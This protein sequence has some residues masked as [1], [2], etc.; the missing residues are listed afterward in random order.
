MDEIFITIFIFILIGAFFILLGIPLL[1]EKVKPNWFYGFRTP[2]TVRNKDFWY[3][4]NKQVGREFIIAGIIVVIGSIFMIIFQ[5][6]LTLI[7][8]IIILLLLIHMSLII[9]ISR[10]VILLRK[11]KK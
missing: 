5:P 10:G 4:V 8:L 9:I 3:I 1:L 11:L 6:I 7:Q 2:K